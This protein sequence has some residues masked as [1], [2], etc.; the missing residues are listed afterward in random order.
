MK[1]EYTC[2]SCNTKFD[3]DAKTAMERSLWTGN[4][5]EIKCNKCQEEA[6]KELRELF[7]A[8]TNA[9]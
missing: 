3:L 4:K 8:E 7:G 9:S 5:F 1:V 2:T 6:M